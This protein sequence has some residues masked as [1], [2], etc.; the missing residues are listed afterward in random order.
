MSGSRPSGQSWKERI[1]AELTRDKRKTAVLAVL[2]LAAAI[3][4]GRLVLKQTS[5]APAQAAARTAV[6]AAAPA[7]RPPVP[8]RPAK[9]AKPAPGPEKKVARPV[10]MVDITLDRDIFCPNPEYFPLHQGKSGTVLPTTGPSK[11]EDH[12]RI[13]AAQAKSLDLQSTIGGDSG[14]A[15]INGRVL[16]V[17]DWI[18]GFKLVAIRSGACVLAKDGVDVELALKQ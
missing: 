12:Q 7:A 8:A 9:P 11:K 4:I 5:S 16:R 14:A 18:S 10:A 1:V 2:F 17:G 3:V 15:I 6:P 13:V